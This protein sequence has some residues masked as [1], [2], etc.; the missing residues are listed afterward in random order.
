MANHGHFWPGVVDSYGTLDS[1]A[2]AA[3]GIGF[4][5]RY[6]D[7]ESR[8]SRDIKIGVV[9]STFKYMYPDFGLVPQR[10]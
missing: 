7:L 2:P 6:V 10:E 5:R 8:R 1:G 4:L 3:G 9:D